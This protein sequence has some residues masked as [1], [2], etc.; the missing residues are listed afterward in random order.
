MP[1]ENLIRLEKS[2][3]NKWNAKYDSLSSSLKSSYSRELFH[4]A[5]EAVHSRSFRGD[6]GP[7]VSIGRAPV[8]ASGLVQIIAIVLGSKALLNSTPSNNTDA[9]VIACTII[10][11][12][13]I[14][15]F[16]FVLGS[17]SSGNGVLLPMIDSANHKADAD[18]CIEYD[19]FKDSF[20]LS[21]GDK[22][23]GKDDQIFISYGNN[24]SD[25][26]LL[27]NYGFLP[28]VVVD[29]PECTNE[30]YIS[31]LASTFVVRNS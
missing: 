28:D 1:G 12:L 23:L 22:C 7:L 19:P 24:K 27:L 8:I 3:M 11:I 20:E 4:W 10:A 2:Q 30:N 18:S 6:F 16:N 9:I 13:P 14:I 21:L 15:L 25:S 17:S 26:E 5:L 29:D 31:R